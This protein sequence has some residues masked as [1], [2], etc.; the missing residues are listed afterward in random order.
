MVCPPTLGCPQDTP[1]ASCPTPQDC[2]VYDLTGTPCPQ[3]PDPNA[4][5]AAHQLGDECAGAKL[6]VDLEGVTGVDASYFKEFFNQNCQGVV[7]AKG[8]GL[9][10]A[11]AV[12]GMWQNVPGKEAAVGILVGRYCSP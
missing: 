2:E 10:S 7:L 1:C 4:A 6:A 12:A 3:C 11:C 9:T 8:S 5:L